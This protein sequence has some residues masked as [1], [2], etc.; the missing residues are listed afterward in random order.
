MRAATAIAACALFASAC[1]SEAGYVRTGPTSYS[2]MTTQKSAEDAAT[3]M[4]N[5]AVDLCGHGYR[6]TPVQLVSGGEKVSASAEVTCLADA[7]A[8]SPAVSAPPPAAAASPATTPPVDP[9]SSTA[10]PMHL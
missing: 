6:M 7:S 4:Q 8:P 2:L 5:R 3:A 1:A 10:V 9:G